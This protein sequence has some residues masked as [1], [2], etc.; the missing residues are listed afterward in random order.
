MQNDGINSMIVALAGRR[1]DPEVATIPRFPLQNIPMV[2]DRIK[3]FFADHR[4]QIVVSSG[5]C[6]ADLVALEIAEQLGITRYVLLPCARSRFMDLSVTDRPGAWGPTFERIYA[7]VRREGKDHIKTY[8]T[9]HDAQPDFA[10]LNQK[11]LRKALLLD[12]Q[13]QRAGTPPDVLALMIWDGKSR[14]DDDFTAAF[15]REAQ[16]L[17]IPVIEVLTV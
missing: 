14:G 2:G 12:S 7:G 11:I 8:P 3:T 16:Q 9:R 5:A 1:I 6:G 15:A 17:C 10:G 4:V 13:S